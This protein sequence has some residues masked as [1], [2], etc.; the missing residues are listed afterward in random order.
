MAKG[1][2]KGYSPYVDIS[3]EELGDWV[4][5]KS[6]VK[7]SRAWLEALMGSSAPITQAES[8]SVPSTSPPPLDATQDQP[9][10]E[11][12]LTTFNDED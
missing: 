4:G 2:P 11:F 5:R 12:N 3:Y 10:I 6:K 1:R 9:K 8:R 7:V